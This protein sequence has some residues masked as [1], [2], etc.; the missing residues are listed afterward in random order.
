MNATTFLKNHGYT[1]QQLAAFPANFNAFM[2]KAVK[3]TL[4]KAKALFDEFL[5][6]HNIHDPKVN[7]DLV[8]Y[9]IQVTAKRLAAEIDKQHRQ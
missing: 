8:D 7:A 4:Q 5:V 1:A 2:N 3:N 6:A 9:W